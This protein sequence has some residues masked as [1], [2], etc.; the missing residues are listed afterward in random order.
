[1]SCF[2]LKIE[3]LLMPTQEA[4]YGENILFLSIDRSDASPTNGVQGIGWMP[5]RGNIF[6][7]YQVC[8]AKNHPN[9]M[10]TLK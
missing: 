5:I 10:N 1:M 9:E 8:V 2:E 7:V 3:G 6:I 4:D